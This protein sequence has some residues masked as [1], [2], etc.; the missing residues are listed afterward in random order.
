[1]YMYVSVS[2]V[3]RT[4]ITPG[5]RNVRSFLTAFRA[6]GRRDLLAVTSKEKILQFDPSSYNLISIMV[7]LLSSVPLHTLRV[8]LKSV[9]I[10]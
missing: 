7:D 9:H 5:C 8:P 2:T 10:D 1:M 3:S 6:S 4:L